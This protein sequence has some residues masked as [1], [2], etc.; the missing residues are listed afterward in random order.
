MDNTTNTKPVDYRQYHH[1]YYL[2]HK[3]QFK[4][5]QEKLYM[6]EICDQNYKSSTV[7]HRHLKTPKHLKNQL[8][9]TN[10][11]N[12]NPLPQS[13]TKLIESIA[14]SGLNSS[15]INKII[16]DAHLA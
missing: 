1:E 4:R 6:C 3:D 13:T 14:K 7:F 16:T 15:I 5:Y 12:Q 10:Q 2:T 11:L 9:Q 8:N